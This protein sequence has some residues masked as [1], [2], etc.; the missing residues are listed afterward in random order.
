MMLIIFLIR[1]DSDHACKNSIYNLLNRD[2][3]CKSSSEVIEKRP[4]T[5]PA[6]EGR[7]FIIE[8]PGFP[9]DEAHFVSADTFSVASIFDHRGLAQDQA[10][11]FL[12]SQ[13]ARNLLGS[14]SLRSNLHTADSCGT[15]SKHLE[16]Q[17]QLER[18]REQN[19]EAQRRFRQRARAE[20]ALIN[21]P[22]NKNQVLRSVQ[23]LW[24]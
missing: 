6:T 15:L 20:A 9:W 1:P 16:N 4:N 13:L 18:R 11:Q 2:D 12:N 24:N 23:N 10:S 5:T 7:F 8:T 21:A 19:R 3:E 14:E 17:I 22:S